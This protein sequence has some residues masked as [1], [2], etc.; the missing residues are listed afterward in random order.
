M[1]T[2]GLAKKF[3][4][5]LYTPLGCRS[6]YIIPAYHQNTSLYRFRQNSTSTITG[7]INNKDETILYYLRRPGPKIES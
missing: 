5:F 6:G 3:T 2:S 7:N 4:L 1:T